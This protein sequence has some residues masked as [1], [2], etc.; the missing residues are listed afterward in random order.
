MA[1]VLDGVR[2]RPGPITVI[3][4]PPVRGLAFFADRE[5]QDG[6]DRWWS[7]VVPTNATPIFILEHEPG[8]P[9]WLPGLDG[10]AV[11]GVDE[12][13]QGGAY[14][15]LQGV[16]IAELSLLSLALATLDVCAG[17]AAF[18]RDAHTRLQR[19]LQPERAFRRARLRSADEIFVTGR[20]VGP[21]P[22]PIPN[23]PHPPELRED[24]VR[25][26]SDTLQRLRR[27][28]AAP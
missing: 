16:R 1:E 2:S 7:H 8:L 14:A 13:A 9:R 24:L 18:R 5:R 3:A 4:V 21:A 27:L 11:V 17:V 6:I 25:Q 28:R 10:R 20:P 15:A 22:H 12:A 23:V 19:S 26:L